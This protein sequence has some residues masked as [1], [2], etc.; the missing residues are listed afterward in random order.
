ERDLHF[1]ADKPLSVYTEEA[2]INGRIIA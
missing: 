1:V 2:R